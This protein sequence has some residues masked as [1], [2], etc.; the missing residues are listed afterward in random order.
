MTMNTIIDDDEDDDDDDDDD[1]EKRLLSVIYEG[2]DKR[3]FYD[4]HHSRIILEHCCKLWLTKR[5]EWAKIYRNCYK[6]EPNEI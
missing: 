2:P 3:L 6:S 1:D 5:S 4:T